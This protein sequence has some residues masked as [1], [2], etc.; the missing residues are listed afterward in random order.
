MFVSVRPLA[1]GKATN[2]TFVRPVFGLLFS[3]RVSGGVNG[4]VCDGMRGLGRMFS[5]GSGLVLIR[6]A[7]G[8]GGCGGA[9]VEEIVNVKLR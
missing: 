2:F 4:G 1:E 6:G 9:R 3:G 5:R 8:R 7:G